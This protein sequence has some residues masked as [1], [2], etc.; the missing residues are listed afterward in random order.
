MAKKAGSCRE[1]T[2]GCCGCITLIAA[3]CAGFYCYQQPDWKVI[4]V[5]ALGT[6]AALGVCGWIAG[7]KPQ[8]GSFRAWRT[9]RGPEFEQFLAV[10]FRNL[11]YVVECI[12]QSGDQG[13]DIIV[14]VGHVRVGV[15]AKGYDGTVGNAAVQ[16]AFT[17]MHFHGCQRC[18]V[19][20]NSTFTPAAIALAATL[21]NCTLVDGNRLEALISG[22]L[23]I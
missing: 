2:G 19:V 16:Q 10:S 13:I 17:G 5:A 12:G 23:A 11:G 20:T 21:P 22:R 4:T 15:Q 14:T 9:L 18:A 3:A 8:P 6:L 7:T 1:Q